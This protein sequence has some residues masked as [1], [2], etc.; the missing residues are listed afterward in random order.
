MGATGSG[1]SRLAIDLASHFAVEI[2]NA[3]S[4]QAVNKF[5][6]IRKHSFFGFSSFTS[7]S[8]TREQSGLAKRPVYKGLDVLTNKVPLEEQKGVPHH[9]LG[10]ISPMV[11]FTA[12]D[13]RD[14]AIQSADGYW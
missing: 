10:T 7:L 5:I 11:E 14:H 6:R 8:D 2:I 12:K 3:D 13:F 1:K 9:L 4:M